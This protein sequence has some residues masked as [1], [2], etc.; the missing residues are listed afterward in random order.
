VAERFPDLS[1]RLAALEGL[2]VPWY[3]AGGWAIDL[4]IGSVT[5]SHHDVDVLVARSD[6]GAVHRHFEY[7][8]PLK[9][10]PH[11]DGLVGRGS[12][13]PWDG[14]WLDLP[15]HQV[16]ADDAD[17]DRIEI[18]FGEIEDGR[19]AY[20]R[21]PTVTV[22]VADL[23]VEGPTGIPALA[24][25]VVLLFKA[26]L[27]RS[28]DDEDFDSVL[29]SLPHRRRSWLRDAHETVHPGHRWIARLAS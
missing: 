23:R 27:G 25:E 14:E 3:V 2:G 26:K 17:G 18:L 4:W 15:I 22:S 29:P 9:V 21:N 24:P 1:D 16:F 20:R 19:W 6:Q 11:P 12:L 8:S 10:I 7:R 28:W 13:E 5:R